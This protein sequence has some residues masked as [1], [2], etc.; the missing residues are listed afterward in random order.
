[1]S[2]KKPTAQKGSTPTSDRRDLAVEPILEIVQETGIQWAI[3][4]V[5]AYSGRPG[6]PDYSVSTHVVERWLEELGRQG[7]RSVINMLSEDE[8][9]VYY[10][11]L[12][13]PLAQYY[14]DAGLEVRQISHLDQGVVVAKPT[15]QARLL[16]AFESLPKPVL[17]H[18]SAGV[19]RSKEAAEG[20]S[21]ACRTAT[22]KRG[23]MQPQPRGRRSAKAVREKNRVV[24]GQ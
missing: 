24:T 17:I 22:G 1:M 18:C 3:P 14:A 11:R 10:R 8:M 6:Y 16:S 15:L 4:G 9:D 12:E 5:L 21:N 20:I 23:S 2:T 7:I 19:E 13:A